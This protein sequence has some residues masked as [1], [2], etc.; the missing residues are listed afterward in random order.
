MLVVVV[1]VLV[2][3]VVVVLLLLGTG[4]CTGNVDEFLACTCT[5][6]TPLR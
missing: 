3:V 5:S 4:W 1:V 2:V 6:L